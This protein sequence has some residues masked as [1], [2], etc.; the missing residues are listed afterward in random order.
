M[1]AP[2]PDPYS[3]YHVAN[4][5]QEDFG[6]VLKEQVQHHSFAF[7]AFP[8]RLQKRLA[9]MH[10]RSRAFFE[11]TPLP[12]KQALTTTEIGD[13]GYMLRPDVKEQFQVR[14]GLVMPWSAL[15]KLDAPQG[16]ISFSLFFY[17]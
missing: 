13:T 1:D 7:I 4:W 10:K 17:I 8:P 12:Y 14:E 9:V 5:G 6:K 11:N 3:K 16:I 2:K 15:D